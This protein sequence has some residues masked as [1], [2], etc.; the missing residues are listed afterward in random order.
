MKFSQKPAYHGN[1]GETRQFCSSY[2]KIH[3]H[4]EL[5]IF[6]RSILKGGSN[7]C[8]FEIFSCTVRCIGTDDSILMIQIILFQ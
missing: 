6:L 3:V 1:T 4:A 7:T 2:L 5:D 8:K